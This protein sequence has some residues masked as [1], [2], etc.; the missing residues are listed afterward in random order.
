LTC[1]FRDPD[2]WMRWA[3]S[4]LGLGLVTALGLHAVVLCGLALAPQPSPPRPRWPLPSDTP[5]LLRLGRQLRQPLTPNPLSLA[6]P[7]GVDWLPPPPPP[8]AALAAEAQAV[9]REGWAEQG[10]P[11]SVATALQMSL[12]WVPASLPAEARTAAAWELRRRQRWLSPAQARGLELAWGA[13]GSAETPPAGLSPGS[14]L[15]W[16]RVEPGSLAFLPSGGLHGLSLLD[17]RQLTLVWR[18]GGA[19][20]LVRAPLGGRPT[21]GAPAPT[22]A[23][24]P[25]VTGLTNP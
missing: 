24:S 1:N 14:D 16:R 21:S 25:P 6:L 8:S 5:E 9:A 3:S 2:A 22:A 17:G 18:K 7:G 12:A 19:L 15:S 10:L 23:S 13:G 4:P 20:W 11:G